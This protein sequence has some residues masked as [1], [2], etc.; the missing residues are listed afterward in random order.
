MNCTVDLCNFAFFLLIVFVRF[1]TMIKQENNKKIEESNL[2][3]TES[4]YT[5]DFHY[6]SV[7]TKFI[8]DYR[9]QHA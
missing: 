8:K 7:L 2:L 4:L 6:F 3:I 5:E 9:I 1:S